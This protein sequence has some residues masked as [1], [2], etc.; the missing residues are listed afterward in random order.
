[1]QQ[2]LLRELHDFDYEFTISVDT[3]FARPSVASDIR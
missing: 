3:L 1:M 2:S